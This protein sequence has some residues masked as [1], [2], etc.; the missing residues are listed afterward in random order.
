M[1]EEFITEIRQL[2][3]KYKITA[4]TQISQQLLTGITEI[5]TEIRDTMLYIS[6]IE[7]VLSGVNIPLSTAV[8]QPEDIKEEGNNN[9]RVFE[10]LE[11]KKTSE[12]N[13]TSESEN[14]IET[15]EISESEADEE[16]NNKDFTEIE[17][18]I[19]VN[20]E[21]TMKMESGATIIG[22]MP[23]IQEEEVSFIEEKS[24]P[25]SSFIFD[26]Y[27]ILASHVNLPRS[28]EIEIYIAPL[29]TSKDANNVPIVVHAYCQGQHKTA[30]SYDIIGNGRNMVTLEIGEFCLLC[31]GNFDGNGV[32]E[33]H[34]L[35]TGTSANCGDK[36]QII[37]KE[38]G[39]QMRVEGNGHLKF[40]DNDTDTIYE[41]FPLHIDPTKKAEYICIKQGTEFLDYFVVAE[42]YGVPKIRSLETNQEL[43]VGWMGRLF[44]AE[45]I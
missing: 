19:V 9:S 24:K 6:G 25:A 45:L 23:I 40:K 39:A 10:N 14:I 3:D 41:I 8:T 17:D 35:T 13:E 31:R 1:K 30:S 38:S 2:L 5:P 15:I 18:E 26:K 37:S 44:E 34:V 27:T 21:D 28:S 32:F 11:Q 16:L 12:T 42:G 4:T 36:L 22:G 20:E 29:I 33:S 7:S 43:V